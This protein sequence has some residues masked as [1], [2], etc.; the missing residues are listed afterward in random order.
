ML[1]KSK[2]QFA[3]VSLFVAS[4]VAPFVVNAQTRPAQLTASSFRIEEPHSAAG[5]NLYITVGGKEKL[6]YDGAFDAWLITADAKSC[7]QAGMARAVL[8]TKASHC[9]FMMWPP[10]VVAESFRSTPW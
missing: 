2:L 7:F 1:R 8:K 6:I 10:A 5:N 4:I 9:G 3:V